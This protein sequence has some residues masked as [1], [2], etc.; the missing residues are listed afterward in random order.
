MPT[1]AQKPSPATAADLLAIPE[2]QRFHEIVDGA[3]VQKAVSS[4]EHGDAQSA[5]VA[6]V[7]IPF[8]RRPGGRWPG[9]WWFATEV[10]VE[11]MP[12][13][14]YRPDV[15]GWRRERSPERPSGSPVR[16]RPDWVCEVLSPDNARNDTVKKMRVYHRCR[17]PHYWIVDPREE[18]L[19]VHRWTPEGYLVALRAERGERVRAEPF[20][21]I[22]LQVG[23][24]FGDEPEDA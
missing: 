15:V 1:A 8:Q 10:E 6:H 20:D 11:L 22:A 12:D 3:L 24:L 5:I 4:F 14:V 9:G 19:T 7:K 18:T 21:A 13:Q 16:L 17:L 2:E 23:V